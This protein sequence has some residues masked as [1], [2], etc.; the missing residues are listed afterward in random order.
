[1]KTSKTS[2][3][4]PVEDT[5][6]KRKEGDLLRCTFPM[7]RNYTKH[8]LY[9]VHLNSEGWRCVMDDRGYE[10][11]ISLMLTEFVLQDKDSLYLV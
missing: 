10:D 1:M 7:S 9:R 5:R 3:T 4:K 2:T 11:L 6:V 8:K